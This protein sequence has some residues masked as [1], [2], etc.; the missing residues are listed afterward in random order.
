MKNRKINSF[1]TLHVLLIIYSL[2][3]MFSKIASQYTFLS[4]KF[5]LCYAVVIVNLGIYAI[6]WQQIIKNM[7]LVTAFANKAV[8]I[9]WGIIWGKLF[10]DEKI[11]VQKIVGAIII[12]IGIV[13]VISEKEEKDD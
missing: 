7:P 9:V 8:T 1:L 2:F 3:G 5:C 13:C 12:I 4:L 6:C 11:T 10:F